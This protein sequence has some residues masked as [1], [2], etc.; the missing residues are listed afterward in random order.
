V[1]DAMTEQNYVDPG[2]NQPSLAE[3]MHTLLVRIDQLEYEVLLLREQLAQ[4]SGQIT[5][6]PR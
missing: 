3:Q 6:F 2:Q 5:T 1:D 4:Q